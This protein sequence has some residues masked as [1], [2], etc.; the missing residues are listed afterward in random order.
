MYEYC[1][2][3]M[4]KFWWEDEGEIAA[5]GGRQTQLWILSF[6]EVTAAADSILG[7]LMDLLDGKIFFSSSMFTRAKTFS[8]DSGNSKP[9][10]IVNQNNLQKCHG[11]VC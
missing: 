5:A 2:T 4:H 3:G 10:P 1:R 8:V 7:P 9:V 6:S 11:N